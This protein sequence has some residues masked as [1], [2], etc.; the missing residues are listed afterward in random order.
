MIRELSDLKLVEISA[1]AS[2]ATAVGVGPALVREVKRKPDK[3][4]IIPGPANQEPQLPLGYTI[5]ASR[6]PAPPLDAGMKG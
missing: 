1:Q 5:R 6:R 2:A 4:A 3:P